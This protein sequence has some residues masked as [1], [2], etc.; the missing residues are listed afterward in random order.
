MMRVSHIHCNVNDNIQTMSLPL[1]PDNK[2][3]KSKCIRCGIGSGDSNGFPPGGTDSILR[4][5]VTYSSRGGGKM[6]KLLSHWPISCCSAHNGPGQ[7]D[8]IYINQIL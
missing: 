2:W 8:F 1:S 6:L 4:M 5:A 3:P 7:I